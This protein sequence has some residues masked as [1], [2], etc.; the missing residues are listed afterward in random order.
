MADNQLFTQYAQGNAIAQASY[1]GTAIVNVYQDVSARSVDSA[2]LASAQQQFGHLPLETIPAITPLPSGSRVPFAP[3]PLFVGRASHLL[4]LAAMLKDGGDEDD[5]HAKIVAITGL[6]GVGKTQL[7]TEFVHRY[8]QYFAGG[9]FWLSFAEANAIPGQVAECGRSGYL[10]LRPDF[11]T[12][13]LEDQI[14]LVLGAWQSA[15]PRLLV[16]DNCEDKA[17]VAQW[18]PPTGASH[19]LIT[20]RRAQWDT[21]LRLKMLPLG[22]LQLADSVQLLR[23]YTP[24]LQASDADFAAISTELGNLPL[25]LHLAGSFLGKFHRVLTLQ[26]YLAQLRTA[27]PLAHSSLTKGSISATAHDENV[28]RTFEVSYR[29][30]DSTSS[31]DAQALALLARAT[32]FAPGEPIPHR[33]LLATLESANTSDEALLQAESALLRLLELG[34][35]EWVNEREDT[36]RMHRLLVKFLQQKNTDTSAQAAVE[37]AL[38]TQYEQIRSQSSPGAQRTSEMNQLVARVRGFAGQAAYTP[39]EIQRI[40]DTG[41]AGNRIVALALAFMKPNPLMFGSI[42]GAIRNSKSA[43][44]QYHALLAA[45]ALLPKLNDSQK[46]ELGALL[47]DRADNIRYITQDTSRQIIS[48][49]ILGKLGYSTGAQYQVPMANNYPS[50]ANN[51]ASTSN[52]VTPQSGAN[53]GRGPTPSQPSSGGK[54]Y[55]ASLEPLTPGTE[56]SAGRYKIERAVAVGGMGAV[57]NAIDTRF[58][59]PCAVKVMLDEFHS[60]ND[61]AQAVEWFAREATLLLDL[62][63]PCIPRVRDFFVEGNVRDFFI[64]GAKNYLVMDFI[65][66]R[67]LGEVLE[68][69]GNIMGVNGARGVSEARAR[70]WGQQICNVLAYLHRQ[71]II[72]RELNPSNI[73]VT[74]REEVKLIDFGIA[75]NFQPQRQSTVIMTVGYAPIEQMAGN[76]EPRSDLYA[77][78]ATLHRVLTHHDAANNKPDIFT[79]PPVRSL[80][81]DISPGFE[82]VIMKALAPLNQRWSDATEMEREIIALPPVTITPPAWP[83]RRWWRRNSPGNSSSIKSTNT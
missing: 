44:E 43:F 50:D 15:L 79:L 73:M 63:H 8:G 78:G 76:A 42:L 65:E 59:R 22:E 69:E 38:A 24:E 77:L 70:S 17:L 25:A 67:T 66:G 34:L 33:L 82:Q 14:H 49:S 18:S 35:I 36:L 1:G 68:K 30:L 54:T 52:S 71:N 16:F 20:S 45:R 75:R 6:G 26:A 58:N 53:G 41:T 81:P 62:N 55:G 13:P 57:Y 31:T 2:T 19:V 12:L 39:A 83:I 29:N 7:A 10:N 46:G 72:F 56:L 11:H 37:Q 51:V 61:W 21:V 27:D 4:A 64:E 3:N 48:M 28:S 32:Y 47:Q 60:E 9:V 40:F 80:R 74:D 23:A 5:H